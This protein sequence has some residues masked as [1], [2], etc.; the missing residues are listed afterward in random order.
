MQGHGVLIKML[1]GKLE[2]IVGF[3]TLFPNFSP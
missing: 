2:W 1:A 3:L